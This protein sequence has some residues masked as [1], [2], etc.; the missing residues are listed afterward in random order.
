MGRPKAEL[1]LS[2]AERETLVRWS[3]RAKSAQSLALRCRIVLA[4]ASHQDHAGKTN[5]QVA[6]ELGVSLPTVGKWRQ[7]FIE[8]RL[9]GL[10]DE[11]RPGAPRKI[12]DEQVEEVVVK[13]LESLPKNATHWSTRTMAK[14]TGLSQS[15]IVRIWHAFALKPHRTDTFKLSTDPL[16]IEKVRDIVG[17]YL[18]PPDR[19]I[20]LSVDEKSQIQ[21]LDR[22]QPGLP[23]GIGYTEKHTHDYVRHGTTSLFSALNVATGEVIGQCLSRHRH[24]EFRRFLKT[25]DEAIPEEVGVTIHV[26]MDNYATHKTL[27]VQRWFARH[28]RY[29]VHFTPTSASWLN[30]VERFFAEITTKRIRRGTFRSV[31]HLVKSI[32]NYL[33][34]HNA[35]PKPFRWT[36]TAD[37]ILEKVARVGKRNSASGH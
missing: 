23:L 21:A 9:E 4:C 17:L 33:V 12:T 19:A 11:A 28:P 16:F 36:V 26:I 20:V 22:T 18:D 1:V 32:E 7:R 5:K 15:A 8:H 25:I 37:E 24:Q 2:D 6:S 35:N 34:E 13:T 30:M 10:H 27:A 3:R 31:K 29:H 14:A